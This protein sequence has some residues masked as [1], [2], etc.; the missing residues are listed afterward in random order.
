[1]NASIS[2]FH[3]SKGTGNKYNGFG[4]TTFPSS[5][6]RSMDFTIHDSSLGKGYPS[7]DKTYSSLLG[8]KPVEGLVLNLSTWAKSESNLR[9]TSSVLGT[10]EHFMAATGSLQRT[11]GMSEELESLLLQMDQSLGVSQLLLMG[12]LSNFTLSKRQEMLDKSPI[13]EP[14]KETLLFSPLVKDKL[15]GFPLGKLQEEG[16]KAPQTVKVD[17]QVSNGQ[18]RVIISQSHSEIGPMKK[19]SGKPSGY[20]KRSATGKKPKVVQRKKYSK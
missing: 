16:S 7:C 15:F 20:R 11:K 19:S 8:T 14:L 5:K 18:R 12:T 4:P 3:S 10:T 2:D 9:L 1:M 13:P 6:I 17:V